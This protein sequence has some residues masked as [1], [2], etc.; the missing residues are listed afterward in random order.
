[1]ALRSTRTWNIL[2]E[3]LDLQP[4]ILFHT[5]V[6]ICEKLG[7]CYWRFL[8]DEKRPTGSAA[9]LVS[10]LVDNGNTFPRSKTAV[11]GALYSPQSGTKVRNS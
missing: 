7:Q 4:V 6:S 9:R 3:L 2:V 8:Y 5:S 11:I 10:C 1:M